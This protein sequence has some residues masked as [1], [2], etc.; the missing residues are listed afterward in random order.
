MICVV[1]RT[2]V[3]AALPGPSRSGCRKTG[4]PSRRLIG[5]HLPSPRPDSVTAAPVLTSLCYSSSR[6]KEFGCGSVSALRG[7]PMRATMVRFSV[8]ANASSSCG[9]TYAPIGE[10]ARGRTAL[11]KTSPPRSVLLSRGTSSVPRA[12]ALLQLLPQKPPRPNTG[13][14]TDSSKNTLFKNNHQLR[15]FSRCQRIDR[16]RVERKSRAEYLHRKWT[17]PDVHYG[18]LNRLRLTRW[19]WQYRA[20]SFHAG[21][22]RF[23]DH[24]FKKRRRK[25]KYLDR[26]QGQRVIRRCCPMLTL[27]YS[28]PPIDHNANVKKCRETIG[29]FFA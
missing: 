2:V 20:E 22:R 8:N 1:P 12:S 19:G 10:R 29:R 21:Q 23:L 6:N 18:M 17:S 28:D 15:H 7:P 11:L 13:T 16:Q 9:S 5:H 3:V 4:L 14:A 27:K 26:H 25:I 24:D